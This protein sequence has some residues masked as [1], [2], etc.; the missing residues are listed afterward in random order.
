[1]EVRRPGTGI[2]SGVHGLIAFPLQSNGTRGTGQEGVGWL[3]NVD[4]TDRT[5]TSMAGTRR[6]PHIVASY[7]RWPTVLA[8]MDSAGMPNSPSHDRF[9]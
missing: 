9:A 6:R 2:C 3:G 4:E 8:S 1:M 5:R 7:L